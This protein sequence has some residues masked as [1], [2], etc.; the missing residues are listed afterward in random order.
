MLTETGMDFGPFRVSAEAIA[1][2]D[3][4]LPWPQ[5]G[6]IEISQGKL[7]I[8]LSGKWL[9]WAMAELSDVRN[10]HL[11]LAAVEELRRWAAIHE[12]RIEES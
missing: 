8:K 7:S 12:P 5:I 2:G 9:P 10:P 1:F 6:A 3:D 4:E 11:F